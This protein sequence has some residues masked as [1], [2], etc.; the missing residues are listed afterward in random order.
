M[1]LLSHKMRKSLKWMDA[2]AGTS[3]FF[4]FS[5]SFLLLLLFLKNFNR[6]TV[7][8]STIKQKRPGYMELFCCCFCQH[9]L[10]GKESLCVCYW[11]GGGWRRGRRR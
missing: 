4:F 3:Y 8:D 1:T 5:F 2:R 11:V 9:L 7:L 6:D 10:E